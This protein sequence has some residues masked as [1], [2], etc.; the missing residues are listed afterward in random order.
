MTY[1]AS[2][3]L[4]T[5]D[6][7][8]SSK[9]DLDDY[10]AQAFDEMT[11]TLGE[12]YAIPL[13]DETEVLTLDEQTQKSLTY[14]QEYLA[15]GLLFTELAGTTG[16]EKHSIYAEWSLARAN[17]RMKAVCSSTNLSLRLE[18]PAANQSDNTTDVN[19][20]SDADAPY[21][22]SADQSSSVSNYYDYLHGDTTDTGWYTK[23]T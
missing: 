12:C 6:A 13:P 23:T 16:S 8:I 22:T 11:V 1:I 15:T 10:V 5:A 3:D 18:W 17:D 21:Y 4:R 20:P 7:T 14:I 9:I 19:V 2:T